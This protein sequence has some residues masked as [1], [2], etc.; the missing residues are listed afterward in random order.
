M[1]ETVFCHY[2]IGIA[3]HPRIESEDACML[4]LHNAVRQGVGTCSTRGGSQEMYI[5]FAS[6]KSE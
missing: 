5:T 4:K 3:F 2:T 6:E 1:T